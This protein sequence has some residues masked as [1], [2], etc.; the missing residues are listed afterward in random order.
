MDFLRVSL[1]DLVALV[2]SGQASAA[3]IFA[4]YRARIDR[5]NPDLRAYTTLRDA[6][7]SFAPP[8]SAFAGLPYAV[9]DLY[10]ER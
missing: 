9:K 5:F 2:R 7:G 10:L 4:E 6:P 1:L 3:D 8:D